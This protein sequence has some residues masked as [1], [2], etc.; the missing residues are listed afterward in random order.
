MRFFKITTAFLFLAISFSTGALGITVIDTSMD[1]GKG[2]TGQLSLNFSGKSG[3]S[4]NQDIDLSWTNWFSKDSNQW[5]LSANY[6]YG[7]KAK[8]E[9]EDNGLIHARWINLDAI[10]TNVDFESFIQLQYDDF[11]DLSSRQLIGVG[12][13]H[14]LTSADNTPT[15][16]ATF[17]A[18]FFYE[19]EEQ[20]LMDEKQYT[21]RGNLYARYTKKNPSDLYPY[22]LH[23]T[24]YVQPSLE[25]MS[26]VRAFNVNQIDFPIAE[27]LTLGIQL[28][29][30]FDSEPFE[31]VEKLD[32]EYGLV[33]TY[34]Y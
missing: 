3:N 27:S 4:E 25:G 14:R 32:I 10:T 28:T 26:D 7:E 1:I 30:D 31:S 29:F 22:T 20:D 13:R 34:K 17:G 8:D 18:G 12:L 11:K 6:S 2:A 33:M 9:V 19:V 16:S 5:L 24:L 23:S 15:L 21:I